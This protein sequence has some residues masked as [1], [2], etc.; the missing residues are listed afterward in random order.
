[1][2]TPADQLGLPKINTAT[3]PMPTVSPPKLPKK[4][5]NSKKKGNGFEGHVGKV[6]ADALPPLK[7]RRSQSSGAILGGMNAKFMEQFSDEA[8]TLFVGDVVPTNEGDVLRDEGW[9]FRFVVECKFYKNPPNLEHLFTGDQ[10]RGWFKEAIIDAEKLKDFGK[11]P[12]LIFKYNHTDTYCATRTG[13]LLPP[14][15][16]KSLAF[17]ENRQDPVNFNVF[18]LKEALLSLEWWKTRLYTVAPTD[19]E[20]KS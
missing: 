18:S 3:P 15:L 7:F 19:P 1:M 14:T 13:T 8:K 6:L 11:E 16:T 20:K 5:V 2:T 9:K 12:I 17:T 10:I 4:R